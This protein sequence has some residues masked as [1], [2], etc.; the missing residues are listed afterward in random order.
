MH[1]V[2]LAVVTG[3]VLAVA[4]SGCAAEA[5][6]DGETTKVRIAYNPNT[7]YLSIAVA[8][9]QGFFADHGLD[10][11]LTPSSNTSTLIPSVGQQFELIPGGPGPILAF[12]AQSDTPKALLVSSQT[13]ENPTDR[14]NTYLIG[15]KEITTIEELSGKT[16]GLNVL[17]GTQY[18][19]LMKMLSD[20][21]ISESDVK[22]VQVP[23]ADMANTLDSGSIDAALAISPFGQALLSEGYNDLGN[24]IEYLLGDHPAMSTGWIASPAWLDENPEAI[25]GFLAAQNDALEWIKANPDEARAIMINDFQMRESAVAAID[26]AQFLSFSVDASFLADWVEP[27]KEA[28]QLPASF[29]HNPADLIYNP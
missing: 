6:T 27:L 18:T 26:P 23:F 16:I 25:K 1:K 8:D 11:E 7:T 5:P 14:R 2:V 10:V 22:L 29:S 15:D 3:A 24:T 12:N 17:S 13:I 20:A 4:A 28:G 9:Q 19:G 21:G